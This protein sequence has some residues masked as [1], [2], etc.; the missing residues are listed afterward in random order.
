MKQGRL[1]S[2]ADN[3]P[4]FLTVFENDL[5]LKGWLATVHTTLGRRLI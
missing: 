2:N 4:Y 5:Q 1:P 3:L